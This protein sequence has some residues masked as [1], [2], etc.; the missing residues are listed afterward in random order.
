[1]AV[2]VDQLARVLGPG[3]ETLR[4]TQL[5]DRAR[6]LEQPARFVRALLAFMIETDSWTAGEALERLRAS[7]L[8]DAEEWRN[9]GASPV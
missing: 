7:R 4:Y 8:A 1:M 9:V 2:E 3:W 6:G 5:A